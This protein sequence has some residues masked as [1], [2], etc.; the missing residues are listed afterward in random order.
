VKYIYPPT[1]GL[2]RLE[3]AFKLLTAAN[4]G[5]PPTYAELARAMGITHG[6]VVQLVKRGI[7]RGRLHHLPNKPRT[8]QLVQGRETAA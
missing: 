6:A 4:D 5:I 3:A 1:K 7:V 8:L 2:Q